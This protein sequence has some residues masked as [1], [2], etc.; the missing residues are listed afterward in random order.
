MKTVQGLLAGLPFPQLYDNVEF[1]LQIFQTAAALEILHALIG[2]VRSPVGTTLVQVF[3]R[4]FVLWAIMFK[5]PS[6]SE[7]FYTIYYNCLYY[8][9][10][11]RAG[12]ALE[13]P[14]CYWPGL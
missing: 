12:K 3:S 6:V 10:H 5:V 13:C 14:C 4:V 7:R 9:D 1:E 8:N 2:L 11:F